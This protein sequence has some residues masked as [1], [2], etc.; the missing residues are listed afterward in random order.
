MLEAANISVCV[1][2]RRL[3][4]ELSFQLPAGQTLAL[5]GPTGSGKSSLLRA[6]AWLRPLCGGQLSLHGKSVQA[7]GV[8]EWRRRVVYVPQ[9]PP[10]L[11]ASAAHFLSDISKLR[12][13]RERE[14]ETW[15][16]SALELTEAWGLSAETWQ[17]DFSQLSGGERQRLYLALVL[18]TR[19]EVLLLDEPTSALDRQTKLQIEATL[20]ALQDADRHAALW[21]THDPEQADRVAGSRLELGA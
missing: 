1:G 12:V 4:R 10:P 2:E 20:S 14:P 21:V 11:R 17:Q 3:F 18:V 5:M 13:H 6:I 15:P 8:S 16:A 9:H 7:W 19:P